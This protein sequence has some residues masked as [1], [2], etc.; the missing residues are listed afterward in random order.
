MKLK[1]L[2]LQIYETQSARLPDESDDDYLTRISNQIYQPIGNVNQRSN[3]P[4]VIKTNVV[5]PKQIKK[6]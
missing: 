6:K 4:N 3:L 5:I 1:E 2:L